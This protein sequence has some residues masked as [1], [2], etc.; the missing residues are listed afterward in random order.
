MT[1]SIENFR[2]K[3]HHLNEKYT[4]G[5]IAL[6]S[7]IL[8]YINLYLWIPSEAF[9][10]NLWFGSNHP[11]SLRFISN[12]VWILVVHLTNKSKDRIWFQKYIAILFIFYI[13]GGKFFSG[14]CNSK[15]NERIKH[16][17]FSGWYSQQIK[18]MNFVFLCTYVG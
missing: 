8:K 3:K 7:R 12:A 16:T 2:K 4:F 11:L 13:S 6:V 18:E 10:F 5:W 17:V 9:P 14:V 15:A 1:E